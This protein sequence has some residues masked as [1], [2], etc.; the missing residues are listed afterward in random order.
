MH[1]DEPEHIFMAW[2]EKMERVGL[3]VNYR[4]AR[5]GRFL[6]ILGEWFEQ[7]GIRVV[8]P[9]CIETGEPTYVCPTIEFSEDVD[10]IMS[11]GGDGTLL[12]VARQVAEKGTP[13]LGVNLGQLGFLT[14]LEMPDLFPSLEKLLQGDYIIESRMMLA[15]EVQREGSIIAGFVALN[16]VVINKGPISR[17]IRLE[18]YVGRDYLTTYR[19]D[20]I[21]IA[22]PTGSTAY[23]LSAGG[24]IV[25]PELEVMIVTPICPHTLYARPFI[26]SDNQKIRVVMRSDAPEIMLTID[27][28]VGYPL[29]KNDCVVIHRADVHTNLVKV[30]KRSFSE[31]LRLKMREGNR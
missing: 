26:L 15:A 31:V 20:G 3:V 24:P 7:R 9:R 11:L 4:K 23:S 27:G 5:G 12:G 1:K 25:N 22:S 28:Q 8:L 18:T 2:E 14:D 13:I 17:I 21:I 6:K 10:I 30:K 29:Q 16:D 19:A